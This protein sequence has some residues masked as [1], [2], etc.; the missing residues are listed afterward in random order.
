MNRIEE[1][2]AR[3]AQLNARLYREQD[4]HAAYADG[5]AYYELQR[6][7]N[8]IQHELSACYSALHALTVHTVVIPLWI[9]AAREREANEAARKARVAAAMAKMNKQFG[10]GV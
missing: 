7:Q 2:E 6:K 8:A 10:G 4:P 5:P 1:L 9:I 3:I